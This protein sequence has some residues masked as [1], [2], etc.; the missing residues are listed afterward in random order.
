MYAAN[1]LHNSIALFSIDQTSG[2]PTLLTEFWTRGDYPRHF[3]IEPN[4]NFM[5]VCHSRSDNIT[6]FGVDRGTG[7]LNFT[8]AYTGVFNPSKIV[9]VSL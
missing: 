4:G 8:G 5:Y 6:S 1:R 7:D 3:A 2:A 9:F